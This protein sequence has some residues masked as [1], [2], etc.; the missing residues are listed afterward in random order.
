MVKDLSSG[1]AVIWRIWIWAA[2]RWRSGGSKLRGKIARDEMERAEEEK[3]IE[4]R[5]AR[6]R[7]DAEGG[8]GESEGWIDRGGEKKKTSCF[9]VLG[10][11]AMSNLTLVF[12]MEDRVGEGSFGSV[13]RATDKRDLETV[14]IKFLKDHIT[15][16]EQCMNMIEIKSLLNLGH[17]PNIVHLKD[18]FMENNNA[19][20]IFENMD[21][22]LLHLMKR[23][24]P[25]FF[26]EKEVR[27]YMFQLLMGLAYMHR[28]GY[29]HRDLKP[30]NAL[31][32]FDGLH[33]KIADLGMARE[34]SESSPT[35]GC[36]ICDD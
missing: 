34:V 4:Q 29:V 18:V 25:I 27:H 23:R 36:R 5:T 9:S 26:Q 35:G 15:S 6:E 19:Y 17:H 10:S 22:S 3:G 21:C 32:D 24:F 8:E 1:K 16:W 28:Q 33:V 30:D 20:L 2:A 31:V 13:W 7:E 14:A 11:I 12:E